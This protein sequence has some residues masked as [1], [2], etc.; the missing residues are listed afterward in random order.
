MKKIKALLAALVLMCCAPLA[1]DDFD[2]SQCW[3]NYGAGIKEGD[4][5]LSVDG[6][7]SLPY[8]GYIGSTSYW[9][10][11]SVF[12]DF[13]VA[14]PIWKLPFSFGGYLGFDANGYKSSAGN[15]YAYSN[16]Y[17]GGIV[18]YHVML[19]PEKLDVYASTKLGVVMRFSTD[20]MLPTFDIGQTI[21]ASW[22]FTDLIGV[23]LEFGYPMTKFG[24]VFKF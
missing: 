11:P 12:A 14:Q 15:S 3:C 19:P 8:L 7:F 16:L 4:M 9:F 23:N 5:I 17:T 2:W 20:G 24:V 1:A 21:G 18:S 13:Q 6:G 10:S 22:Y